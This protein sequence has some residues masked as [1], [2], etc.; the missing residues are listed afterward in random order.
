MYLALESLGLPTNNQ[1]SSFILVPSVLIG[2]M[3]DSILA[4]L[5]IVSGPVFLL[6]FM[7]LPEISTPNILLRRARCLRKLTGNHR[8]RSQSEIDQ[9]NL[10]PSA[11]FVDVSLGDETVAPGRFGHSCMPKQAGVQGT[12]TLWVM[13]EKEKK[14]NSGMLWCCRL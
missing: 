10:Q 2:V 14:C 9:K 11:S 13:F 1:I 8:L 4:R 3:S 5:S 6:M 12:A 7:L